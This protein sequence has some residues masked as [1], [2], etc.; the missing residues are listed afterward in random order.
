LQVQRSQ[1][2]R[3]LAVEELKLTQLTNCLRG[4]VDSR[5]VNPRE[6]LRRHIATIIEEFFARRGRLI[7]PWRPWTL[8]PLTAEYGLPGTAYVV[9]EAD[10]HVVYRVLGKPE[11]RER[12]F[13]SDRDKG[14]PRAPDQGY[15]DFVGV[16]V[17]GSEEL[18]ETHAVRFPKF[19]ATVHLQPGEGFM[20][21]RTYADVEGHYTLWG[22]PEALVRSV[23]RVQPHEQ[24]E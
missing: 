24:P 9:V 14:R 12:D 18:A 19:V 13:M 16:S 7:A 21:A 1:L 3:C 8:P 22:D 6:R 5:C 11:A 23:A 15:A 2:R 20:L 10:N 4:S 17:F